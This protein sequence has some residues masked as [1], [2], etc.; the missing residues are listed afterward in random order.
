MLGHFLATLKDEELIEIRR[1]VIANH[2]GLDILF[3]AQG[4][5]CMVIKQECCIYV[6]DN[7]YDINAHLSAA[8]ELQGDVYD[9]INHKLDL[10]YGGGVYCPGHLGLTPL[11]GSRELVN[12]K[13]HF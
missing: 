2:M 7:S 13:K 3:A 10:P 6:S 8:E 5:L 4:R 1:Q 11:I 9:I 12:K